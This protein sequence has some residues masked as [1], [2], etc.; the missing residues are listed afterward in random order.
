MNAVD[1]LMVREMVASLP[2]R[3]RELAELLMAGHTQA[4]AARELRLSGRAVRYR[5]N[6]IRR[7]LAA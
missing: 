5:M 1:K 3:E 4:S 7:R 6:N 2:P